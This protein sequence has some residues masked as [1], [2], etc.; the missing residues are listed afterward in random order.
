MSTDEIIDIACPFCK[1]SHKYLLD[2]LR[3]PYHFGSLGNVRR[4]TRLFT[5]PNKNETFE[6]TMEIKE[7]DRGT[8]LKADVVGIVMGDKNGRNK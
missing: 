8:I 4:F 7:D 6:T 5:C 1:E 3:S 2:V